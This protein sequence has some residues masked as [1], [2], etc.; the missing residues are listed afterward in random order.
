MATGKPQRSY[1]RISNIQDNDVRE[2]T[3]LLWDK[4]HDLND[5]LTAK[6]AAIDV[7]TEGYASLT[8][9]ITSIGQQV[10]RIGP[11]RNIDDSNPATNAAFGPSLGGSSPGAGTG[12]G[13]GGTGGGGGGGG[14]GGTDAPDYSGL[15]QAAWAQTGINASSTD[16]QL[17]DFARLAV[18]SIA[19]AQVQHP[20][21]PLVG[22]LTQ[23]GG[24]G[25]YNCGGTIYACFRL[26]FNNGAN[27]KI[28][29]GSYTPQ[30]SQESDIDPVDWHQPIDPVAVC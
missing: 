13:G 28:L 19:A 7:L 6:I 17:F 5:T 21:E 29:T 14:G 1:P 3:R 11:A 8:T 30:W 15:V 27:I 18:W 12:G 20:L 9:A 25:T 10:V 26:C 23:G 22:L 4:Y 24:D 16:A 2:T